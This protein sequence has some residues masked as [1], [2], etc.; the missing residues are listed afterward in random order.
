MR[1][2]EGALGAG[3]G[4]WDFLTEENAED[5]I[6]LLGDLIEDIA[7]WPARLTAHQASAE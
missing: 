1:G 5:S 7:G 4:Q 6:A 2:F 3:H